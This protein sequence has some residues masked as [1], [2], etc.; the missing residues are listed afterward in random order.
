MGL[1]P[2]PHQRLPRQPP[3]G[4][5]PASL[6]LLKNIW[7]GVCR[8]FTCRPGGPSAWAGACAPA[9]CSFSFLALPPRFTPRICPFRNSLPPCP[10]LPPPLPGIPFLVLAMHRELQLLMLVCLFIASKLHDVQ[11]CRGRL[12]MVRPNAR[13]GGGCGRK[14]PSLGGF[15]LARRVGASPPTPYAGITMGTYGACV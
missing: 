11:D 12:T 14:R 4:T 5:S 8:M 3:L 1:L 15:T 7:P 6:P 2:F 10:R 9:S 13:G